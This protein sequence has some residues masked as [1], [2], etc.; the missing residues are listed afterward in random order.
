VNVE[1]SRRL[2]GCSVLDEGFVKENLKTLGIAA[3]K[4]DPENEFHQK[5]REVEIGA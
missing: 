3:L 4:D 1:Y 5:W 2:N